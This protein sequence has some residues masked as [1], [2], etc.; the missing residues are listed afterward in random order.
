MVHPTPHPQSLYLNVF[1]RPQV[2]CWSFYSAEYVYL[3]C[4]VDSQVTENGVTTKRWEKRCEWKSV[5]NPSGVSEWRLRIYWV[6]LSKIVYFY[7]GSLRNRSN[8]SDIF[9]ANGLKLQPP[10]IV[11][12]FPD[13]FCWNV[14]T[15]CWFLRKLQVT[16]FPFCWMGSHR[17]TIQSDPRWRPT[18][19]NLSQLSTSK[20]MWR[21]CEIRFDQRKTWF[22]PNHFDPHF[23]V[24]FTLKASRK[25]MDFQEG[26][27]KKPWQVG[28]GLWSW[29]HDRKM[30]WSSSSKLSLYWQ[31]AR[32]LSYGTDCF[33]DSVLLSLRWCNSEYLF[34]K[35][36]V[37]THFLG[38]FPCI[39][40]VLFQCFCSF[41]SCFCCDLHWP[42]YDSK[43]AMKLRTPRNSWRWFSWYGSIE[44]VASQEHGIWWY[45]GIWYA[46]CALKY[47][48]MA[49]QRVTPFVLIHW[50]QHRLFGEKCWMTG[51]NCTCHGKNKK[52][53]L[54][55]CKLFPRI[56]PSEGA[57]GTGHRQDLYVHTQMRITW[58]NQCTQSLPGKGWFQADSQ[59][60][61]FQES[62]M[63]NTTEKKR[64][65]LKGTVK[66]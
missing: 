49:S 33:F 48:S 62:W 26:F 42:A 22:T 47:H 58:R 59:G 50:Y 30:A 39:F 20:N 34:D 36:T 66:Q 24:K 54:K 37:Y 17:K 4:L 51:W 3:W 9:F 27:V 11:Y 45:L 8:L 43:D 63:D 25:I 56:Q 5:V 52:T 35:L 1:F 7:P 41:L 44:R 65:S 13:G 29:Q 46:A 31:I 15:C 57:N 64:S 23:S 18:T 53:P 61:C 40:A 10:A 55:L 19:A 12:G 14:A 6:V 16:T 38:H 28:F 60:E 2:Q 32:K 21:V